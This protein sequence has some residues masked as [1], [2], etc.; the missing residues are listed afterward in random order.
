ME[1]R[2]PPAEKR[3]LTKNRPGQ[4][5]DCGLAS[6]QN[7]EKQWLFKPLKLW[8]LVIAAQAKKKLQHADVNRWIQ[9]S[10]FILLRHFSFGLWHDLLA[11][12][13][14]AVHST[15]WL[16]CALLTG[17]VLKIKDSRV[18]VIWAM[19]KT[20]PIATLWNA[21]NAFYYQKNCDFLDYFSPFLKKSTEQ[22]KEFQL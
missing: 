16:S 7:C 14:R 20:A 1:S 5:F 10:I 8:H 9:G 13:L 3:V 15:L 17:R 12:H 6:L 4:H 11:I 21:I 2:C 19:Q 18:T 22:H